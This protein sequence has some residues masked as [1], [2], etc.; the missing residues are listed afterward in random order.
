M[1]GA[2]FWDRNYVGERYGRRQNLRRQPKYARE[3]WS[4]HVRGAAERASTN[5]SVEASHLRIQKALRI[6]HPSIWMLLCDLKG[7]LRQDE[8][9]LER[10][11]TGAPA[12]PQAAKYRQRAQRVSNLC[13][14]FL[15]DDK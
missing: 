12:A 6:D 2:S 15:G 14:N 3:H 11:Q 13:Q 9:R 5:K 10:L 8:A 4:Q 1:V 7:L